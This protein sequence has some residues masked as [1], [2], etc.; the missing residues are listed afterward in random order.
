MVP[1]NQSCVSLSSLDRAI[2]ERR[3]PELIFRFRRKFTRALSTLI[4]LIGTYVTV[5]TYVAL[6]RF[7]TFR[8]YADLAVFNQAFSSALQGRLF[9]ETIDLVKIPSGSFLGTHFAPLMFLLLPIY[10]VHPEPETLLILQTILIALGSVPVYLTSKHLLGNQRLSLAMA[11]VY[12]ANPA[13]QSLNLY[14][15]HLEAFLPFFLGMFYY[16]LVRRNWRNY[17][18]FLCLSLIT[19]EFSA[20]LVSTICLTSL[21]SSRQEITTVLL[22]PRNLLSKKNVNSTIPLLTIPLS[23]AIL[24]GF[25]EASAPL[26]GVHAS[27]QGL[28]A[29]FFPPPGQGLDT[30]YQ[31]K[32]MF[33]LLLLGNLVF[34]P[35]LVPTKFLM[36]IPWL[37][38]TVIVQSSLR[39]YYAIGYQY[40]GA[41]VAPYLI[42]ASIHGIRRLKAVVATGR[43]LTAIF[44]MSFLISPL[45][46]LTQR[47][48]PGIAYDAGLPVTTTHDIILHQVIGLVPSNASILT[49]NDLIS[50]FS[51]RPNAFLYLL[52]S[53]L[54]TDFILGDSKSP[55]YTYRPFQFQPLSVNIGKALS[56]GQYG[57]AVHI[58]GIILLARGYNGPLLLQGNMEYSFYTR[59]L[60]LNSGSDILDSTSRSS[61]VFRHSPTDPS[62]VVFWFGPFT[63]LLP[64]R[65]NATFHLKIATGT[66]GTLTLDVHYVNATY[67]TVLA[68]RLVTPADFSITNSWDSFTLTFDL[69]AQ[70]SALGSLEFR[71]ANVTGGPFYF[72]FIQ[73]TYVGAT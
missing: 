37:L 50:Q 1:K 20:I 55:W 7:Y 27:P 33:W 10:A 66:S 73:V 9:Y 49:Q 51:G 19:I 18:L 34:L 32:L 69:T 29:G 23:L 39:P 54:K 56:S 72:D 71:G 46:P 59:Q 31:L 12:L 6:A 24:Y 58:D 2:R 8:T 42:L 67:G 25:L 43:V 41:F 60:F 35:L 62:G 26:A 16:S 53:N 38:V 70:A 15:F 28:L 40:S 68:N 4:I 17:S 11:A 3:V 52:D 13:V 63:T 36:A 47:G 45:N 21:L 44:L 64:G 22:H 48:L 57:V 61:V 30:D 14:D 5:M 65:Y